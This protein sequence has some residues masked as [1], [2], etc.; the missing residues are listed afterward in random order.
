MDKPRVYIDPVDN[1][2]VISENSHSC[3]LE[4]R[5][6]AGSELQLVEVIKRIYEETGELPKV[7]AS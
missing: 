3:G 5:W 1:G 2:Y 6:V 4:R 7:E